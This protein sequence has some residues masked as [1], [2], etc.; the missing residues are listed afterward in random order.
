MLNKNVPATLE[1]GDKTRWGT[2][3][4]QGEP[5][6]Y[7]MCCGHKKK[8]LL[9]KKKSRLKE[10]IPGL[11]L[12]GTC[13]YCRIMWKNRSRSC[14]GDWEIRVQTNLLACEANKALKTTQASACWAAPTSPIS[15]IQ[16][17]LHP[18]CTVCLYIYVQ[19]CTEIWMEHSENQG[20]STMKPKS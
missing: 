17:L 3:W 12:S 20:L 14:R 5:G 10:G 7:W 15:D 2:V 8:K 9:V 1:D 4:E 6:R 11:K 18:K 19:K 16:S 13:V